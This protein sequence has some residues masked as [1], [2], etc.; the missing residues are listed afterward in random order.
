MQ[1][2]F[3]YLLCCFPVICYAQDQ[4]LS[5]EK[6]TN[7]HKVITTF[8]YHTGDMD[9]MADVISFPLRRQYPVP[10]IKDEAAIR[11]RFSEVFDSTLITMIAQSDV[12]QWT[13]MGW[14][15]IMLGN[16]VV[17]MDGWDGKITAVN[18][19][20]DYEKALR[21]ELI[22]R[23]KDSLHQSLQHFER[24]VYK[25]R[26]RHYLIRID[27]LSEHIYRYASWK[28]PVAASSEP[29]LV[30]SN[31]TWEFEGTG[32][33]HVIIFVN[34][35]FTYKIYRNIIG[36][37]DAPDITLEVEKDGQRIMTEGGTLILE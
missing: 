24:P 16:G 21:Q 33:N 30:L 2:R 35:A 9:K 26:T 6:A 13:E 37:E 4:T 7:I 27:E 23:D 32:G 3:L 19:E 12:S 17:W 14:R 1:L 15:G 29:D 36:V 8:R 20:S 22:A 34:G 31:G 5:S 10:A 28:I 25:I 18:Y 11:Q